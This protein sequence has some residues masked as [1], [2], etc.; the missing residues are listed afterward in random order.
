[1]NVNELRIGNCVS[2][3]NNIDEIFKVISIEEEN[4]NY[5]INTKG[6]KNG[7][8]INPIEYIC[9]IPLTEDI[10][11]KCGFKNKKEIDFDGTHIDWWH[12]GEIGLY[13]GRN[14]F[15]SDTFGD[16][17]TLHKLQNIYY[18]FTGKDLEI[19]L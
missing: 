3:L 1:M 13:T 12:N 7:T 17:E 2:H 10:L 11:L 14:G 8:W 18:C 15:Y 6:G 4:G 9:S 16:I 19:D 5:S